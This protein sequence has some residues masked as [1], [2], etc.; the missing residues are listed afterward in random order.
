MS[1]WKFG[2]IEVRSGGES[3]H[4]DVQELLQS[5]TAPYRYGPPPGYWRVD[6]DSDWAL[7]QWC[8]FEARVRKL[9]LKTDFEPS[10]NDMPDEVR[11]Y[12]EA[13]RKAPSKPGTIH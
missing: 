2:D 1:T 3:N 9:E 7:H 4:A 12:L 6:P 5:G 11:R 8:A 10:A 13:C